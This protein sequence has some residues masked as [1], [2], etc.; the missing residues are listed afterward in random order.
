MQYFIKPI[1]F[2]NDD[3][4]FT[5][6]FTF[7][8]TVSE[9]SL[10]TSNFSIYYNVS[11]ENHDSIY[12]IADNLQYNF[13]NPN[14]LYINTYK[15]QYVKRYT[16]YLKYSDMKKFFDAENVCITVV[17]EN[18]NKNLYPTKKTIKSKEIINSKLIKIIE[19]NK[20]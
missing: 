14:R 16:S 2:K 13:I 6:D 18:E 3:Y 1:E 19:L 20:K 5:I 12:F 8:D 15:K 17:S 9:T 7:R 10:I 4:S 11:S